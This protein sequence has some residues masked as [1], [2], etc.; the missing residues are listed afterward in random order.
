LLAFLASCG[1]AS[2]KNLL[3]RNSGNLGEIAVVAP[4]ELWSTSYADVVRKG[5]DSIMYG[6]PQDELLLTQLEIKDSGFNDMFRTH[7]NVLKIE[8]DPQKES[9]VLVKRDVYARQQVFI[10]IQIKS[11]DELSDVITRH[12][13]SILDYFFQEEITRLIDRNAAFGKED[14]N[15]QITSLTDLKITLQDRFQ[16]AVQDD[17][18]VWIRL[19]Q[20]KPLG[21]YQHTIS[22]GLMI[23]SRPYRDTSDFSDSSLYAWKNEVNKTYVEG[24]QNSYM[25]ISDRFIQPK[26]RLVSFNGNTAKEFRGLWRMEGYFMGGPFYALVFFNPENGRQ[27]M[28]E[29][30]A[31]TPQ[32]DKALFV[33]EIE[34]MAKSAVPLTQD[35]KEGS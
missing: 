29:G 10:L 1:E 3:P 25:S 12:R 23:Y 31:Y 20:S 18:F 35:V 16:L 28:I 34:A 2:R 7:R 14:L 8:V 19:D 24:P 11:F 6:L 26:S 17:D 27:Y 33:R 32:F 9:K 21:G 5:L 13:K 30:Y 4:P 15:Q 22:Q